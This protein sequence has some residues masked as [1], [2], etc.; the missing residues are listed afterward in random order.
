[1]I[2]PPETPEHA[3]DNR[4]TDC[5]PLI[6]LTCMRSYSS[7]VSNMLGQHPGL[8][9][10]P[11]INPFVE[12]TLAR[13]VK[14]AMAVRPRTLDRLLR[15]IAEVE[16]GA[17]TEE[18]VAGAMQWVDQRKRWNIVQVLKH[19]TE[20]CA[21]RRLIDKSPSTV[22]SDEALQ[23]ALDACP[24]ACFLH[25][26]SHPCATT[27]S[28]AKITEFGDGGRNR[29]DPETSWYSANRRIM[30]AATRI[31]R[32]QFMSVR[33]EDVL[34]D[35]EI[36]LPQICAWLG[37]ETQP[38]DLAAMHPERSPYA[39]IGPTSAPFGNDPNFLR[40]PVC[41]R[42]EIP[43]RPLSEPLDWDRPARLL[44]P[45]SIAIAQQMGYGPRDIR[46]RVIS[47]NA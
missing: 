15:A 1:M 18:C 30:R 47:V 17:Q 39:C 36:Y 41:S 26:Y 2:P 10:L 3:S 38:D 32:G 29:N 7:L 16:F 14:R 43:E 46:M 4:M 13:F 5:Q 24:N 31:A 21:P 40:N 45:E 28:I 8:Y 11:E 33:G 25:L 9:A 12:T 22:L 42:R 34:R 35:P 6:I 44:R 20:R 23:R 19:L 27:R 37:L